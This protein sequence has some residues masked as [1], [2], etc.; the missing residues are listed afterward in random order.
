[1]QKRDGGSGSATGSNLLFSTREYTDGDCGQLLQ[2]RGTGYAGP[3]KTTVPSLPGARGDAGVCPDELRGRR[4]GGMAMGA[5][6]VDH[7][8]EKFG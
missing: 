6:S 3:D 7:D 2:L 1:M 4:N 8:R 5:F